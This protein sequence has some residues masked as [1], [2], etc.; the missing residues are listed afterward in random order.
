MLVGRVQ[1]VEV[2]HVGAQLLH[3]AGAERVARRDQ[4]AEVVL[5]QPEADLRLPKK[6]E[7]K[8]KKHRS[9]NKRSLRITGIV[10][11]ETSK[12]MSPSPS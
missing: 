11:I 12:K 9:I 10:K 1:R 5:D 4:H 8:H 3:G 7:K 2:A 6:K